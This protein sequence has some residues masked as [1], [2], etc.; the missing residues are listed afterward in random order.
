MPFDLAFEHVIVIFIYVGKDA[1]SQLTN[2]MRSNEHLEKVIYDG[3]FASQDT[4]ANNL[5]FPRICV[6]NFFLSWGDL[7]E[8]ALK[9]HFKKTASSSLFQ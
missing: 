3:V 8:K 2:S 9:K 7:F 4:N 1:W 6:Q 5:C